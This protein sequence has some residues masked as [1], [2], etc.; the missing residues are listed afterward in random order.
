MGGASFLD[1]SW[2][3]NSF[4]DEVLFD[5]EPD[6]AVIFFLRYKIGR[7]RNP[8]NM[9]QEIVCLRNYYPHKFTEVEILDIAIMF[10][11][12]NIE[13]NLTISIAHEYN[14]FLSQLVR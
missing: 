4:N 11:Q 8:L 10:K 7:C 12:L 5:K 9:S 2:N 1:S 6:K 3:E 14:E 13:K